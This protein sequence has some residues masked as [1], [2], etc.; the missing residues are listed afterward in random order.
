MARIHA[1]SADVLV[2]EFEFDAVTNSVNVDIEGNHGKVTAYADTD[3]T[4]VEGKPSFTLD[5]GGL[6][7]T[8]SP[9][10][11]GEMFTD[12]T[13]VDRLVGV[14]PNQH[15]A[16]EFGYECNC[17]P[18]PQAR[19]SEKTAAILLNVQWRGSTPIIRSQ[20]LT[21]NTAISS[22]NTGTAYQHGAVGATEKAWAAVRLLSSPG[23]GGSNDCDV[24]IESD[25]AEGFSSATT[26][27]T[28]T[29]L[30]QASTA[31]HETQEANGAITD[32]WWRALVTIS[33]GGSRTFDLLITMG[34]L[35]Q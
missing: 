32:D 8:S 16:G 12:L 9:G 34:I 30:N 22:T 3:E 28:F 11:D 18:G 25:S 13:T 7:S 26:R 35:P 33:G 6:F 17:N 2:D 23:G 19:T 24:T 27:L 15:T 31:T 20:V 29:T 5:I 14:Y 10:Y 1:K 4:Y 21:K